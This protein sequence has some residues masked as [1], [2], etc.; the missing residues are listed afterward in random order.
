MSRNL[1]LKNAVKL[2]ITANVAFAGMVGSPLVFAQDEAEVELEEITVTGS[3]IPRKDLE[4]PSPVSIYDR[5]NIE[6]SGGTSIGQILREIPAVAGGA[7]ATNINNGGTG[8]QNISLRGLGSARTLVLIN[9]RRAPDSSGGNSGLVDLNTIPVAMVERIEVLKDGASAIYGSDA[10]A[11]V[12]NVITRRDFEGVELTAQTGVSA[13]SDGEKNE[14]S[15]TVGQNIGDANFVMSLTRV[16][17]SETIAGNRDWASYAGWVFGGEWTGGGSSAPPWGRYRGTTDFGDPIDQAGTL[18][19][20]TAGCSFDLTYG[21]DNSG[22]NLLGGLTAFNFGTDAYNY[23]PINYQRQPNERWIF[24]TQAT[25]PIDSLSGV[26]GMESTRAFAELQY[27]DRESAQA[28]AEQPLAP[29][30]FYAFPA[31]YSAQNEYNPTGE[32][33]SDWR[34][35]MVE[36][37]PRTGDVEIQTFRGVAGIEGELSNGMT[38]EA[39]FNYGEVDYVNNYGPLY[40]LSKVALAVGPTARDADNVI[41][42]DTNGDGVFS[43]A[44]DQACVP[45]N[46]FGIGAPTQE[47]LDYLQYRE[48]ER[49]KVTQRVISLNVTKADLFEL[50]GGDVGLSAGYVQRKE[51]GKYSPDAL[52]LELSAVGA[53][54]G[55]P[56]DP[57]DGQY[58]VDELYFEMRFPVVE[59]LEL[60]AGFRYSDYDTFGDTTN[61]KVGL[62]FRPMDDILIRGSAA[63]SFRAPTISNLFGGSGISFPSVTD[64]CASNPTQNCINDGVPAG[65]FT[66]ISTQVRTLVGGNPTAEPEEADTFTFG[67]VYQPSALEGVSFAVDYWNVD[68]VDPITTIGAGVILSQCAETG[69]FCEKID[70]FGPGPNQGA[71][72]LIDNRITNAGRI[73]TSGYDLLAEWKGIETDIGTFGVH[74]EGAIIDTYDKTQANGVVTP[75]AGYFRDDEDGHFAE[76]RWILSGTYEREAL[77]VQLDYRF[78]DEVT[79]F[80]SDIFGS[81]VDTDGTTVTIPGVNRGLTCVTSTNPE[82]ANNLGDFQHKLESASYVD[83]YAKYQFSDRVMGFVGIDNVLDEEPPVSVDGFNDN[84]DVRTFDTIGQYYYAGFKLNF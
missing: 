58:T 32:D 70:R 18:C 1:T 12:V 8:S 27:I 35:R 26:G 49:N 29:L 75:H 50:P 42:C 78:I 21:P 20:D 72:L 59:M 23:A 44:D 34:R 68:I 56:S 51:T 25:M 61:W 67:V 19:A 84:T 11:G 16:E 10:I 77:T 47:M 62:Q 45:L 5:T 7:Q 14:F 3:R 64:P 30:A 66:Q 76:F 37:G 13:E 39:A 40:N 54:T 9:G 24:N 28:L 73:E 22:G 53:V 31:T 82:S 36:D 79:E 71:P 52:T 2:A 38:W 41:R 63:T 60:D 4:G 81:C 83:L 43:S 48:T 65:G 57:T 55:T 74:W 46:T 33:I 80:G 6:Q 69:E 17:E 15:L